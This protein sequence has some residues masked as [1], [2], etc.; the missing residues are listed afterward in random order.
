M[1]AEDPFDVHRLATF[2]I[3]SCNPAVRSADFA[4]HWASGA[5]YIDRV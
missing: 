3:L 1:V 2:D 4:A 5:K